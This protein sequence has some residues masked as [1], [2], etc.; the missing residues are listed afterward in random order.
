MKIQRNKKLVLTRSAHVSQSGWTIKS[1][2]PTCMTIFIVCMHNCT[3]ISYSSQFKDTCTSSYL[4]L[5]NGWVMSVAHCWYI[6]KK[7]SKDTLSHLLLGYTDSL[8][9]LSRFVLP[10]PCSLSLSPCRK[11]SYRQ[12]NILK[13]TQEIIVVFD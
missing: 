11:N 5:F 12:R 6:Y 2:N 1:M 4:R 8:Y 3:M 13:F 7:H 10:R 9:V